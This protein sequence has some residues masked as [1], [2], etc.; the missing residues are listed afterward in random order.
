VRCEVSAFAAGFP[1]EKG[2]HES[3][4]PD[5]QR[6]AG[7]VR[8]RDAW[9]C[10]RGF[11][12]RYCGAITLGAFVFVVVLSM[13]NPFVVAHAGSNGVVSEGEPPAPSTQKN[14]LVI[15]VPVHIKIP[16][17]REG[18]SFFS[19]FEKKH[20]ANVLSWMGHLHYRKLFEWTAVSDG[21]L[22]SKPY[23]HGN[24]SCWREAVIHFVITQSRFIPRDMC[25]GVYE[26]D[27]SI[28]KSGRLVAYI[29][30]HFSP[31]SFARQPKLILADL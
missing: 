9:N 11:A 3:T 8:L 10:V 17:L 1:H 2:G 31:F 27:R 6:K 18:M 30:A 28:G 20:F 23:V 29:G 12:G 16:I 21:W 24:V 25:N 19:R 15:D 22:A 7:L 5:T 13:G 4:A 14:I 26:S